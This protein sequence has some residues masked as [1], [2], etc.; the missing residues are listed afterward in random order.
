MGSRMRRI[1]FKHAKATEIGSDDGQIS[2]EV[3]NNVN[4]GKL[5]NIE[6]KNIVVDLNKVAM[7]ELQQ[8]KIKE[9]AAKKQMSVLMEPVVLAPEIIEKIERREA[10][11]LRVTNTKNSIRSAVLLLDRE[12][13][14]PELIQ[15]LELS[16]NSPNHS[17]YPLHQT[18]EELALNYALD[19]VADQT[20]REL[21]KEK[22][23]TVEQ[24][25]DAFSDT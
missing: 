3:L 15:R 10:T 2:Y 20:V 5:M 6:E 25:A 12:K 8:K 9:E 11:P 18:V 13:L 14:N 4:G 16:L 7:Y 19:E 24:L 1:L 21:Q 23:Y 22:K 17:P